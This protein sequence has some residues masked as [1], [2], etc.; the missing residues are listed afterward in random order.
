MRDDDDRVGDG[1]GGG[2]WPIM[3][4]EWYIEQQ[5]ALKTSFGARKSQM[6][7]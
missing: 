7:Q 2:D 1:W 5:V 3:G 6:R 4:Q